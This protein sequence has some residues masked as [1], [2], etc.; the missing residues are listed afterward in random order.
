MEISSIDGN[1]LGMQPLVQG[2]LAGI[3]QE[4]LQSCKAPK[5]TFLLPGK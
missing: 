3:S 4:D 1:S 2:G 5:T